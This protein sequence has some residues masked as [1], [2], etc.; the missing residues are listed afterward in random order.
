MNGDGGDQH[1]IFIRYQAY[2]EYPSWRRDSKRI[3]VSYGPLTTYDGQIVWM[4][5]DGSNH[6]VLNRI[7]LSGPTD[8]TMPQW[9]ANTGQ[10]GASG[11][12]WLWYTKIQYVFYNNQWY[13]DS[14]VIR[15]GMQDSSAWMGGD[16]LI[17]DTE[18]T[19]SGFDMI[20]SVAVTDMVPPQSA[21]KG[22]PEYSRGSV[23]VQV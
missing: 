1:S 19:T 7:Y 18:V 12:A 23:S 9:G 22:M 4:D 20:P 15:R 11:V 13:V 5:P 3:A 10:Y 17:D 14:S 16:K 8:F 6:V 2:M 21:I